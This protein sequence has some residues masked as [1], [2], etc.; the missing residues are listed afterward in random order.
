MAGP[1][2]FERSD[3]RN[4]LIVAFVI[5]VVVTAVT[6]G[7]FGFRLSVGIGAAVISSIAFLVSTLVINRY[8]P[9]H[10]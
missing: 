8:K 6:S 10:W 4:L 1:L 7:P 3:A 9:D 2:G 5:T